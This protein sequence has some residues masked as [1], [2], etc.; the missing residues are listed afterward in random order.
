MCETWYL[1]LQDADG[2]RYF[3]TCVVKMIFGLKEVEA[4][5]Q[6]LLGL[7]NQEEKIKFGHVECIKAERCIQVLSGG[8]LGKK[9]LEDLDVNV[10]VN[11]KM[12]LQNIR[13]G[14]DMLD[15]TQNRDR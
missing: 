11:I 10:K 14:R 12:D 2:L 15:L 3:K 1:T 4:L 6:I 9:H 7:L 8:N 13:W 5:R